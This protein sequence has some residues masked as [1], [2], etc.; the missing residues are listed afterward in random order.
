MRKKFSK[1][2]ME[3]LAAIRD[4]NRNVFVTGKAGTGKSTLLEH[5]RLTLGR[6]IVVL[7]PTGIA[8]I[9]VNG[10]TIHSFFTLKPGFEKDEA[11][12]MRID[13]KKEKKFKALKSIAIDEISMVRAD[14]LDAIDIVLRR[15][16]KSSAPFGGVQMVFFGDLY[17][18]PPV[19]TSRDRDK[20]FAEYKS[21][22]FFDAEVF[23]GQGDLFSQGFNIEVFELTKIYRQDDEQFISIL[24]AV[25]DK[26]INDEQLAA[27]NTRHDP[28]F[29]PQDD[30][31]YIYLMTTN[32]RAHAINT[33]KLRQLPD[34]D[35]YFLAEQSGKV[36]HNL[37]LMRKPAMTNIR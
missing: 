35:H 31:N 21:P 26:S 29:I 37:A 32:V 14:L 7:A 30:D 3:I 27:L 33:H 1:E 11:K 8:A 17:Q 34:E 18:L 36:A 22:Y 20:Y 23:S 6:K 13:E 28:R 12:K 9:N 24:N 25:R 5:I 19:I 15:A 10:E 2:A 4:R 16:R